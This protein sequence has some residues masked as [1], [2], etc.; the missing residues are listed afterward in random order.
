MDYFADLWDKLLSE[1]SGAATMP[2]RG[3]LAPE[4]TFRKQ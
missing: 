4:H 1:L 2:G 3:F